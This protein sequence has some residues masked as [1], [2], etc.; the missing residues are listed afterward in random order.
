[1][2]FLKMQVEEEAQALNNLVDSLVNK[3]G[4][5]LERCIERVRDLL[6]ESEKI[7]NEELEKIVMEIPVYMY[8]AVEGLEKLGIEGDNAK[9]MRKEIFNSV[10]IDTPGTIEDKTKQAELS[11]M[12]EYY[13][14]I[15]FQRAYKKLKEKI[16][17]AEHVFTGAKKVL[18]KRTNEIFLTKTD[19]HNS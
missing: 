3:Y 8:F 14:E 15:A 1:M 5:D 12:S 4:K 16:Q 7:S 18:D 13:V 17:K 19:R 6:K 11:T 9:A 2:R 10:Y